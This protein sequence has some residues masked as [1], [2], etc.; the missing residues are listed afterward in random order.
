MSATVY[1]TFGGRR[2]HFDRACQALRSGQDLWDWDCDDYCRH[3]H[4]S[5]KAVRTRSNLGAALLGYTAC[6]ACVPPALALPATGQTYGHEP[7]DE[8]AGTPEGAR[9]LSRIV[10]AR[11]IRWTRWREVQL[12]C[13]RRVDWP[14]TSAV[15]LGLVSRCPDCGNGVDV[16][17]ARKC[18]S[19]QHSD[20]I[21][22][23]GGAL[24]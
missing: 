12:Y 19:C 22:A 15:V 6:Q 20:Q 17:G 3:D 9:G 13:G 11:C 24:W 5:A 1:T 2:F 7:V 10:C 21:D 23:L 18:T 4:R 14:C 8:Y 16:P